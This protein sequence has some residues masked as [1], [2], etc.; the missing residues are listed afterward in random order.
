LTA[1]F[2]QEP[3]SGHSFLYDNVEV[4]EYATLNPIVHDRMAQIFRLHGAVDMEPPLLVPVLDQEEV[5]SRAIFLD[6]N[7]KAVSL[8]DNL[9]V[10]FARLAARV[11]IRRIKRYHINDIYKAESV[12]ALFRQTLDFMP[13]C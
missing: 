8:P 3:E 11:G 2:Q 4:P 10:P 6:R 7:G 1:L 9:F 5:S 12:F 13:L